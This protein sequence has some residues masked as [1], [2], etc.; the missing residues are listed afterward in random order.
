MNEGEL[1][2]QRLHDRKMARNDAER[3][4]L[5]AAE[6]APEMLAK[7]EVEDCSVCYEIGEWISKL[8]AAVRR[9]RA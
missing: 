3:T 4:V 8:S 9:L 1:E 6:G 7:L 5:D 2:E